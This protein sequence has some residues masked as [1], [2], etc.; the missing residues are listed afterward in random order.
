MSLKQLHQKIRRCKK[1]GLGKKRIKAVPGEGPANAKIMFIGLS[2]GKNEDEQGKP[3][4]GR[5]GKLLDELL[6]VSGLKRNEAFITSVLKCKTPKNRLP[7]SKEV[8]SCKPYLEKQI[9]MIKPRI[10]VL[11][12]NVALKTMLGKKAKSGITKI[13]RKVIWHGD[14]IYFPT[15]HP[16]AGIRS[17]G[18]KKKLVQDFKRLKKLI[19]EN[20]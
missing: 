1:C 2:P 5:A 7:K 13:H 10:I 18:T 14:I 3:F 20:K 9:E 12:G 19:K 15:F 4:V 8:E 16:A 11:L 17:T 6:V